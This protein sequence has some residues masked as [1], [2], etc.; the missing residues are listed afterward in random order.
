M[1][2]TGGSMENLNII[3]KK[4]TSGLYFEEL[5]VV[6]PSTV[7]S[8]FEQ[9]KLNLAL[10]GFSSPLSVS[11]SL[12]FPDGSEVSDVHLTNSIEY[13]DLYTL[14]F[15]QVFNTKL[16]VGEENQVK[17]RE[18]KVSTESRVYK[19]NSS[20]VDTKFF[21]LYKTNTSTIYTPDDIEKLFIEINKI[22]K[23][24]GGLK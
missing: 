11:I 7:V 6:L 3:V 23:V 17:I 13:P 2:I 18:I 15:T 14:D 10:S 8:R 20:I 24:L 16:Q 19:L 22:N 4:P 21:K 1:A 5:D 9:V 12:V